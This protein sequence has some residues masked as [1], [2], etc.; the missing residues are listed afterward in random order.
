MLPCWQEALKK[1]AQLR[2]I[3]DENN[4]HCLIEVDGGINAENGEL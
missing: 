1:I 2:K 4:Y 3:I